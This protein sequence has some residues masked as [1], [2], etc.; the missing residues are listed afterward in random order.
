MSIALRLTTVLTIAALSGC[1]TDASPSVEADQAA[2]SSGE[3]D[4]S[5]REIVDP[6]GT[7]ASTSQPDSGAVAWDDRVDYETWEPPLPPG[8]DG[9][10]TEPPSRWPD[11]R[12][13]LLLPQAVR[14]GETV[15]YLVVL[16]NVSDDAVDL[17]PCGGYR[18]EVLVVGAGMAAESVN[19]GESAFRLNCDAAP[20]LLPAESRRY[21]MRLVVP[22][23]VTGD[24]V[25]FTW[26]FLDNMPDYEA[27]EWI[28]LSTN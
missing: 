17:L 9:W 25:L 6:T 14:P 13:R 21:A 7:T 23:V 8:Q 24:E 2:A 10:P 16:R 3:P 5:T 18:Q 11:L 4:P 28:R 27:Q 19:G 1:G 22:D 15:D 20:I 26:G 12:A